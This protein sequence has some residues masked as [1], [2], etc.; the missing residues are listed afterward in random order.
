MAVG[1]RGV[2]VTLHLAVAPGEKLVVAKEIF[3]G[4]ANPPRAAL[5]EHVR[6]RF[7]SLLVRRAMDPDDPAETTLRGQVSQGPTGE[8]N[9]YWDVAG[10]WGLWSPRVLS[11]RDGQL[12]KGDQVVDVYLPRRRPW[13]VL[14]VARE[15][16]FGS[17]AF[18]NQA[19]A[20][21]PCPTQNEFGSAQG[22]DA[23][24]IV[25][26]SFASPEAGLGLRRGLPL[27]AGSSCPASNP[28]GCYE[29]DYVVT[30]VG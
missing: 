7:R 19:K 28:K 13:R 27:R 21:W 6:V 2:T 20:L 1:A 17:L 15:C 22:D 9:V 8:W 18:S 4:W 25:L 26:D 16:D 14:S 10:V 29:L 30:R 3:L 5:P 11:V 24:G 12:V 23:P